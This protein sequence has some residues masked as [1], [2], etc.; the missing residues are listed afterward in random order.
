MKVGRTHLTIMTFVLVVALFIQDLI[1]IN[2]VA[3][4]AKEGVHQEEAIVERVEFHC[5]HVLKTLTPFQDLERFNPFMQVWVFWTRFEIR[6]S[7][8]LIH[9]LKKTFHF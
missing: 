6:R 1:I 9:F 5:H 2:E 8:G 3:I 7:M 4:G